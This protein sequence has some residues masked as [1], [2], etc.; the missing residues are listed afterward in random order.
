[1]TTAPDNFSESLPCPECD[2]ATRVADSRPNSK[3]IRRRRECSA[4]HR[5]TTMELP[6]KPSERASKAHIPLVTWA[7]RVGEISWICSCGAHNK[8]HPLRP[9]GGPVPLACIFR[10]ADEAPR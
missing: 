4:G 2:S 7:E 1:M 6:N 9:G 5:F 3:G 10:P 8:H